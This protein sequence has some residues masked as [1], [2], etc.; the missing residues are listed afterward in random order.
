MTDAQLSPQKAG[1]LGAAAILTARVQRANPSANVRSHAFTVSFHPPQPVFATLGRPLG[2]V[3]KV[4]RLATAI[5]ALPRVQAQNGHERWIHILH[6]GPTSRSDLVAFA[7]GL[8]AELAAHQF[9]KVNEEFGKVKFPQTALRTAV[10]ALR[11]SLGSRAMLPKW[12]LLL[13]KTKQALQSE[14]RNWPLELKGLL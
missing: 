2:I 4:E 7:S 11:F 1:R 10:A 12:D 5:D 3:P 13:S 8:S 9:Y 14:N 6:N